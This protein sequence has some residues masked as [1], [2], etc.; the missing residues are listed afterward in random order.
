MSLCPYTQKASAMSESPRIEL[1]G[2]Q[3]SYF[4]LPKDKIEE[5][6]R[7]FIKAEQKVKMIEHEGDGLD[8]P[9]INELRYFGRHLLTA[10][11]KNS[12]DELKKAENH[13]KRALYDACEVL[14]ISNLEMIKKFK[15]DYRL[16]PI[17]DVVKDFQA[18]MVESEDARAFIQGTD[19]DSRELY[20]DACSIHVE[21]LIKIKVKLEAARNDL[22]AKIEE[23]RISSLRWVI[24]IAITVLLAI[25]GASVTVWLKLQPDHAASQ[26]PNGPGQGMPASAKTS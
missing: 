1:P 4:F 12:L 2:N 14:I 15:D 6:E 23:K 3:N 11:Q 5:I 24:G 25:G 17:S 7:L 21:A 9:S 16:V 18:I 26:M 20:Y 10:L 13:V 22:N 8:I 19:I